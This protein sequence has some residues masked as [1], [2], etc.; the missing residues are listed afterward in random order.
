MQGNRGKI[1]QQTWYKLVPKSVETSHED[2]VTI[3]WN[4][5]VWT[6]RII[7]NNKPY[8]IVRVNKIGT[9]VLIYLY[10]AVPGDRNVM[11]KE[12]EKILKYVDLIT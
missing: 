11:R 12:A 3:L 4:Q 1:R 2:K 7:P 9:S 6:D 5:Q 8:I 10:V